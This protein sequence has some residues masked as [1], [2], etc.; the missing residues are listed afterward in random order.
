MEL[1]LTQEHLAFLV[2]FALLVPFLFASYLLTLRTERGEQSA[3]QNFNAVDL[4]LTLEECTAHQKTTKM[5]SSQ[6][7]H[8]A[9]KKRRT[10]YNKSKKR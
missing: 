8:T 9:K 7:Q 2:T 3:G 6:S 4:P 10:G 5:P 1:P